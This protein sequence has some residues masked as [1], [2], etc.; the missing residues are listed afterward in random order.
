MIDKWGEQS[1]ET[2]S[3]PSGRVCVRLG[4][5]AAAVRVTRLSVKCLPSA[6]DWGYHSPSQDPAPEH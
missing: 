3:V 1:K 2:G 4:V 6:L 5:K